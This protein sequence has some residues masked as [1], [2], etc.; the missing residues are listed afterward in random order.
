M[1]GDG[2]TLVTG[3]TGFVGSHVARKLLQ[4]GERVR[5]LVRRQSPLRNLEGLEVEFFY[6]DLTDR[7]SVC[8]AVA[9]CRRVYHVAADY[10]LWAPDPA[11]LYR[12]NVH[13]TRNILEA[14]QAAKVERIV[15]TSTVGALGIPHNGAGPGTEET[16][17]TLQEM[18]GH[19]KRSKFLAEAEAAAAARAGVPVV[20]V[21]PSTPVGERDVKPTPTGQ[22]IV[23][24]L[25]GRMPAYVETGL[26]LVDVEDVAEGHI[27]AMEKGRVGE[28]YILGN[29][30]L[31]LKQILDILSGISRRPAPTVRLPRAAA[32]GLG[33]ISTGISF[34]TKRSPRVPWEGVRMAGKRMFF[35][36]SK[37]VR[38]LGL[39]QSSIEGALG[40]AVAWFRQNG[41]ARK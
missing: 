37:A 32:L 9:G 23:D 27:L 41:Y 14:A 16:P 10:R 35:D 5:A 17:V 21:N 28:R 1:S 19:Y 24:F 12:T 29:Q 38:E 7:E 8:Q 20:I 25:N 36:S 30:N 33:A 2:L 15:Y 3:A 18:V 22:M 6:G 4:S 11:L 39:P 34:I 26:N 13:G 40:K 31:T